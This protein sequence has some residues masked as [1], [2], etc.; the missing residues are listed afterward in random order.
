M[1]YLV[2]TVCYGWKI[3]TKKNKTR[4]ITLFKTVKGGDGEMTSALCIILLYDYQKKNKIIIQ[5]CTV[6]QELHYLLFFLFNERF[7]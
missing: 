3:P 2:R 7:Q 6:S 4:K 5:L 1:K